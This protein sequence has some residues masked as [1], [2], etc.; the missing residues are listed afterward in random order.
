MDTCVTGQDAFLDPYNSGKTAYQADLK[1]LQELTADNPSQVK[2]WQDLEQRAAAWQAQVTEPVIQ[3]RRDVLG[4][5][6]TQDSVVAFELSGKGKAAFDG[7]RGVFA[8][9]IGAEQSL[10]GP[11]SLAN[12]AAQELLKMVLLLGSRRAR[13]G[14]GHRLWA[15]ADHDP[16][17][18]R[19]PPPPGAG[20][21]RYRATHRAANKGRARPDG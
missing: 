15:L 8:E 21:G 18:V 2:R 10:M 17:S 9:G 7:M 6:A 16:E 13:V 3:L 1:K 20:P 5:A 4:G 11:R 14:A 19:S 12:A